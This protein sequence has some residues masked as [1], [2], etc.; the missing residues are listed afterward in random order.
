M[1]SAAVDWAEWVVKRIFGEDDDAKTGRIVRAIHHAA[2]YLL[3]GGVVMSFT[4]VPALWFQTLVLGLCT[5]VWI[6]HMLFRGCLLSKVEQRLLKDETSFL[7]P[8]LDLCGV[9]ATERSKQG[10]LMMLS[11]ASLAVFMLAWGG[12]MTREILPL[13]TA[14]AKAGL[15][16][17]HIP[18]PLSSLSGSPVLS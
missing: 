11:T 1:Q 8:Y 6:H 4:L 18:L 2:S 13:L 5:I 10:I 16:A 15:P 17:L 7:D 12:R 14:Q 9:E 3:L